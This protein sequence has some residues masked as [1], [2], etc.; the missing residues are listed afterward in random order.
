M[1]IKNRRDALAAHYA[2]QCPLRPT[3]C[4][5][6]CGAVVESRQLDRHLETCDYRPEPKSPFFVHGHLGGMPS[7]SA[8]GTVALD[9][10]VANG[11]VVVE[12]L[13]DATPRPSVP[14]PSA[15]T[16]GMLRDVKKSAICSSTSRS[17]EPALASIT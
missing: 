7:A 17:T 2:S 12:T 9:L 5:W 6:Q 4:K 13:P 11:M 16:V 14:N 15:S 1:A 3:A 10:R 8:E